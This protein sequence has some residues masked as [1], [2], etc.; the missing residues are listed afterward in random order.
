MTKRKVIS[1]IGMVIMIF[2]I[3]NMFLPFVTNGSM[4]E[5]FENTWDDGGRL[6]ISIIIIV[7]LVFG[8]LA[9]LMQLCGLLEHSKFAYFP[10]GFYLTTLVSETIELIDREHFNEVSFGY[11]LAVGLGILALILVFVSGFLAN[12]KKAKKVKKVP[13]RYDAKT[14]EPIYE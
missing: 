13:I 2:L 4:F 3:V 14:G 11:W 7:E 5:Y 6:Q 9:F 10:L 8:L 12:E 1:I